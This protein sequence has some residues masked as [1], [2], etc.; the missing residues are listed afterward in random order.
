MKVVMREFNKEDKYSMAKAATRF[1]EQMKKDKFDTLMQLHMIE[2]LRKSMHDQ[3]AVEKII[4]IEKSGKT[5]LTNRE[6]H[7]RKVTESMINSEIN[8]IMFRDEADI[9]MMYYMGIFFGKPTVIVAEEKDKMIVEK[10]D[11]EL[12]KKRIYIPEFSAK[13]LSNISNIIKEI[14]KKE[15]GTK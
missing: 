14:V 15:S 1:I 7:V 2:F 8:L 9:Y 12:I 3:E 5:T 13:Y 10:L 6:L 4:Q 11:H